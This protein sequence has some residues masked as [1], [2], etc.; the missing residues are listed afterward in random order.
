[1]PL[2]KKKIFWIRYS[3]NVK[4]SQ[5]GLREGK[6]I[7]TERDITEIEADYWQCFKGCF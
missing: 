6:N 7:R 4:E 1:M 2:R 3:R 5:L